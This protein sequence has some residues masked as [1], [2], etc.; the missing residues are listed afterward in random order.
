MLDVGCGEGL[1]LQ[2]LA[3]VADEIVGIDADPAAVDRANARFRDTNNAQN[4]K[5]LCADLLSADLSAE[6]FDTITCVAALHHMPLRPALERMRDLLSA[7]G[8]LEVVGLAAN[9]TAL[10]WMLSAL[11][12]VPVHLM[13][14][15]HHARSDAGVAI[16]EPQESLDEVRAAAS[17]LLPGSRVHRRFYYRYS[18]RW[19]KPE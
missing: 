17:A 16:A 8:Q 11:M 15:A 19:A 10:D 5:A 18:L 4:A 1:L 14:A 7:G 9:R 6:S 3:P 13:S 12:I 2:R